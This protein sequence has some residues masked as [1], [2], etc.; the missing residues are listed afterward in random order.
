MDQDL[1]NGWKYMTYTRIKSRELKSHEHW[2]D[3]GGSI[4]KMP[5]V[6]K[7]F[8]T[9]RYKYMSYYTNRGVEVENI[10]V[11]RMITGH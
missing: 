3:Q 7:V 1:H 5:P 9:N 10:V 4:Y 6:W 2:H 8:Y 11:H